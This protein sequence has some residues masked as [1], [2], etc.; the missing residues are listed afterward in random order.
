MLTLSLVTLVMIKF[1][2]LRSGHKRLLIFLHLFYYAQFTLFLAEFFV[3][4]SLAI[5]WSV[6]LLQSGVFIYGFYGLMFFFVQKIENLLFD[7]FIH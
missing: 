6:C 1:F 3:I 2:M 5:L 7:I 4:E